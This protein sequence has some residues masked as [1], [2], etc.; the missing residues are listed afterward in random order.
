M[1]YSPANSP[2]T[3]PSFD[4]FTALPM[5][6]PNSAKH[7]NGQLSLVSPPLTPPNK[8]VNLAS[9][10]LKRSASASVD[11]VVSFKKRRISC[12]SLPIPVQPKYRME[13]LSSD[14]YLRKL[15]EPAVEIPAPTFGS[16]HLQSFSSGGSF[17]S[18][19]WMS[20]KKN[21]PHFRKLESSIRAKYFSQYKKSV[22]IAAKPSTAPTERKRR[23]MPTKNLVYSTESESPYST[24]SRNSSSRVNDVSTPTSVSG[25]E[26]TATSSPSTPR[27]S[28]RTP[29]APRSA[30]RPAPRPRPAASGDGTK[31]HDIDFEKL[32]NYAPSLD[33]LPKG[34]TLS[35]EWKGNPID[36]TNDSNLHLLDPREYELAS[37]LRLSAQLYADS[38][39]RLF[40]EKVNRL[41]QGLPFRRTDSQKACRI[42]VNKA[43]RL[44]AA[45]ENVGWLNDDLFK[46]YL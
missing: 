11:P 2:T 33:S 13:T 14:A 27:T 40:A 8:P 10:P 45:F 15:Q 7:Q 44:F 42:D 6:L 31:V 1:S 29:R 41:R 37:S 5:V 35:T 20:M 25:S 19:Y 26:S 12:E 18:S 4:K 21:L 17:T 30:N 22:P 43:S 16:Y 39:R 28:T 32:P 46:Q 38:K 36:L 3:L 23:R 9:V 34:V 24:R